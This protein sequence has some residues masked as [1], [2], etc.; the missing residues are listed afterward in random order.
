MSGM[1]SPLPQAGRGLLDSVGGFLTL[2]AADTFRKSEA[3]ARQIRGKSIDDFLLLRFGVLCDQT[4][5][6]RNALVSSVA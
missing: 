5:A 2:L 3:E 6:E 4:A 1:L